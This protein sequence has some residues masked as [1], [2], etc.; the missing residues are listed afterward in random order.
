MAGRAPLAVTFAN[1]RRRRGA[2]YQELLLSGTDLEAWAQHEAERVPPV[3]AEAAQER[4]GEGRALRGQIFA[5]LKAA[6]AGEPAPRPAERG[7]AA[8]RRVPPGPPL[9]APGPPRAPPP[10]PAGPP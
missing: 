7:H 10:R 4:L 6:V 3:G 9:G 5:L 1:T 2:A 8:P